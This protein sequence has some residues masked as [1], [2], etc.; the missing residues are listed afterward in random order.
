MSYRKLFS[1][2]PIKS[3]AILLGSQSVPL[4]SETVVMNLHI[5]GNTFVN[6][7]INSLTV[8]FSSFRLVSD[9]CFISIV[10]NRK[11]FGKVGPWLKGP[12]RR[13]V[14]KVARNDIYVISAAYQCNWSGFKLIILYNT[15]FAND[16]INSPV[17]SLPLMV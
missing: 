4:L 15:V 8:F 13:K 5:I 1:M 11:I 9:C 6:I 7:R 3:W 17:G 16:N 2:H 12:G 14:R 10:N